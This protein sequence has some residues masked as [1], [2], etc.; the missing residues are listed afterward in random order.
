MNTHQR[1]LISNYSSFRHLLNHFVDALYQ[2]INARPTWSPKALKQ[3]MH[4][5]CYSTVGCRN[6]KSSSSTFIANYAE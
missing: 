3:A 4:W 2:Y 5:I 6:L 1:Q